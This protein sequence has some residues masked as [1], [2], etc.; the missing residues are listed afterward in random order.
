MIPDSGLKAPS[1]KK[2]S[3]P[4]TLL[5]Y[6]SLRRYVPVFVQLVV[7]AD[8][9]KRVAPGGDLNPVA[10]LLKRPPHPTIVV[11]KGLPP[12][13]SEVA[14]LEG[15]FVWLC[16]SGGSHSA[17][18]SVT[19][20]KL[21]SS[22]QQ[23]TGN[24]LEEKA[25]FVCL[26]PAILRQKARLNRSVRDTIISTWLDWLRTTRKKKKLGSI[27]SAA[28][29]YLITLLNEWASFG[30]LLMPRD[31]LLKVSCDIIEVVNASEPTDERKFS[32]LW[33]SEDPN[34][35]ESI[36]K[37]YERLLSLLPE[38]HRSELK[39]KAGITPEDEAEDGMD[40]KMEDS[41]DKNDKTEPVKIEE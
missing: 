38:T 5:P 27:T 16:F 6:F 8:L 19:F 34:D 23:I 22:L 10:D 7:E 13:Q 28:H 24:V 12:M 29:E 17:S 31:L 2:Q 20:Q 1:D 37:E 30:N 15:I 32:F 3:R 35:F 33:N 41:D 14:L 9:D 39:E 40:L 21:A 18:L 11:E 25:F 26:L 36:K 4:E